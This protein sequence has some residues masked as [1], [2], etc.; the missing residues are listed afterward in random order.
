[1]DYDDNFNKA[2]QDHDLLETISTGTPT[3]NKDIH[4]EIYDKFC[5]VVKRKSA[6]AIQK[7]KGAHSKKLKKQDLY[8]TMY[9]SGMTGTNIRD[10]ITGAYYKELVG[11]AA[12]DLFFKVT[13]AT[14]EFPGGP[15]H[16]FYL[17][18]EQYERHQECELDENL[19]LHWYAKTEHARAKLRL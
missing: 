17:S 8:L 6:E 13:I 9:S 7:Q 2:F 15:L 19:K 14:G 1:M 5:H 16:L 11:S 18:P 3:K 12:Q 10:A 4:I